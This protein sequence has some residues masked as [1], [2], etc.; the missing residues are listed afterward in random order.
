MDGTFGASDVPPV[1]PHIRKVFSGPLVLNSD[2]DHDKA[3]AAMAG[4]I[5]DA[6]SFGRTFLANPDLPARL[7]V[8]ASLNPDNPARWYGSSPEGYTDYPT[9]EEQGIKPEAAAAS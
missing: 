1:S 9:M 4:G 5:P 7:A 8:N 2:Y 6:I 3:V